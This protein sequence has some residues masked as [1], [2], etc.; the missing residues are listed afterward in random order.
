MKKE[1][2]GDIF[3]IGDIVRCIDNHSAEQYLTIGKVYTVIENASSL[4]LYNRILVLTDN[5]DKIKFFS[6]RFVLDVKEMRRKKL[7]RIGL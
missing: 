2:E 7:E 5:M 4:K 1:K 6:H 3:N